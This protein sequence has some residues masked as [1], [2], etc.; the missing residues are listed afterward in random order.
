M[1]KLSL[2]GGK[3]SVSDILIIAL[4]AAIHS[5][6]IITTAQASPPAVDPTGYT[7]EQLVLLEVIDK[8]PGE[9]DALMALKKLTV[10]HID[11][12]EPA[13]A[14]NTLLMLVEDNVDSPHLPGIVHDIIRKTANADNYQALRNILQS[15]PDEPGAGVWLGMARVLTEAYSGNDAALDAATQQLISEHSDD[16]RCVE[17]FGQIAYAF[18]QQQ[19]YARSRQY[20]QYVVSNW[21]DGPRA[22]F[23]Q[24]GLVLTNLALNDN[25]GASEALNTLLAEYADDPDFAECVG[26]LADNYANKKDFDTAM[27]IHQTVSDNRSD[28]GKAV[29]S[30]LK[31]FRIALTKLKDDAL[32]DT[33]YQQIWERF[34]NHDR[35]AQVVCETAWEYRKLQRYGIALQMYRDAQ[36]A[37]PDNDRAII[38]QRGI[39]HC[40]VGLKDLDA[41]V[42]ESQKL[43][44]AFA[45]DKQLALTALEIGD[46][47]AGASLH[48]D[49]LALYN[50]ILDNHPDDS[51]A[52]TA[53]RKAA[54]AYIN[55]DNQAAAQRLLDDLDASF[56]ND[57]RMSRELYMVGETYRNRK[58]YQAAKEIYDRVAAEFPQTNDAMWSRQRCMLM[59]MDVLDNFDNPSAQIPEALLQAADDFITDY[60]QQSAMVKPLLFAGE[61]YYNRAFRKDPTGLSPEAAIE[62]AKALAIFDKIITGAPIDAKYTG[63]AHYMTAV[64]LSRMGRHNDAI[65]YHMA[66]VDNWP[67][68]NLAGSSQYWV[69]SFYQNLKKTGTLTAEEADAKSEESFLALFENYPEN[70]MVKSARSQLGMLYYRGRQWEKAVGVYEKIL[71]ESPPDEKIPRSTYYLAHAYEKIGQKEMAIQTYREY[72][73]AWPES[74]SA[75]RAGIAVQRLGGAD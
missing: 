23:S 39:V 62:F 17:A 27:R 19:K 75:D 48:Q 56:A 46:A 67:D 38:A 31:V 44:A 63:D 30:Q 21:P 49:A 72:I 66:L 7:A 12:A 40:L 18:R 14:G 20:Y 61:E 35:I 55:L 60:A 59:D 22:V 13:R 50:Y 42:F 71:G 69:G 68:H 11:A 34:G 3:I 37:Q 43:L 15:L 28:D 6:S 57:S 52:I 54:T 53:R 73:S 4:C 29:W 74:G 64:G 41:A 10:Q 33:A 25:V 45:D 26:Q 9:Y 8:K 58:N 36:A 2:Y 32:A 65:A 47:L 24:R 1:C 70:P 51:R 16:L 5:V